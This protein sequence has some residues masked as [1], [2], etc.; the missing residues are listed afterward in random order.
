MACREEFAA[1]GESADPRER[2]QKLDE[3][4]EVI[5]KLWTGRE[6]NHRGPHYT[7]EGVTFAPKPVK[8]I[9]IWVGGNSKPA[10]KRAARWN[11]WFADSCD[12]AQMTMDP[13]DFGEGVAGIESQRTSRKGF[14]YVLQGYTQP[15]DGLGGGPLWCGGRDMVDEAIHDI[16]GTREEMLARIRSGPAR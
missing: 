11:G 5:A 14:E 16:R 8:P 3:G 1:F 9:P 7:V 13:Q 4:L 2:A 15:E 10:I 6:T 12:G